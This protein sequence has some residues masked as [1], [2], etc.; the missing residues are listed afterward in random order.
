MNI[1]IALAE[2]RNL[3]PWMMLARQVVP[4][5]GPMPDFE[6]GSRTE[7][8]AGTGFLRANRQPKLNLQVGC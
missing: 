5:S 1:Q 2:D 8:Q 3:K 4:L 6:A 7:D